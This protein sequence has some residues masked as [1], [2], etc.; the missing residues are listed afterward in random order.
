MSGP[1]ICPSLVWSLHCWHVQHSW[2]LQGTLKEIFLQRWYV[3][4]YSCWIVKGLRCSIIL[5]KCEKSPTTSKYSKLC[6]Y[7]RIRLD[8]S[9]LL[10]LYFW[11][12][13]LTL[14]ISLTLFFP[15]PSGRLLE[16][17]KYP[18]SIAIYPLDAWLKEES[19]DKAMGIGKCSTHCCRGN[20]VVW[21]APLGSETCF[22]SELCTSA[23]PCGAF[24]GVL[25]RCFLES[26]G[27]GGKHCWCCCR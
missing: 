19:C 1:L 9:N 3:C 27:E 21:V 12:D 8:V 5:F 22:Q 15:P 23:F 16:H 11:F 4:S 14:P 2:W 10:C 7:R 26:L 6:I 20:R 18:V 17:N 13:T 24:H 25:D